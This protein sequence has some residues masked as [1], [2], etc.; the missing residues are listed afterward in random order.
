MPDWLVAIVL[1]IVEGLTEFLPVSSTGHLIVVGHAMGFT[2]EFAESFEIIIQLGAIIAVLIYF[3]ERL[4][5]LIRQFPSSV[6]ARRLVVGIGL[7]FLPAAFLGLLTHG[8]I[9]SYLFAPVTVGFALIVGGVAILVIESSNPQTKV[10]DLEAVGLKTALWVGVAQCL[11]LF[12]GISRSGATIMG[13]LLIG[14]DRK[15]AAEFSF[16]LAIP[17]MFAAT[18]Y[19]AYKNRAILLEENLVVLIIGLVVSFL[20]AYVV[21]AL[22]LA[23]IRRNTFRVFGVYRIVFGIIVLFIFWN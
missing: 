6:A 16:F 11:A 14:M 8:L 17:T 22:F 21:I 23:F 7:A 2:G 12:P 3:R 18:F 9:R 13:A 19:D 5:L 1:G 4:L 15:T 20:T 10:R